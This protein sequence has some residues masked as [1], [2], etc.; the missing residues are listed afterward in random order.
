MKKFVTVALAYVLCTPLF[1]QTID[2]TAKLVLSGYV[3]AYYSYDFNQPL[4][5]DRPSFVYS[6]NRHN[7]FNLNLGF[8]KAAYV[9]ERIRGNIALMAGTYTNANLAAE[10]AT[11]RHIFEANAG[12]KLAKTKNL[13]LDAGV[14][15]SHIGFESAI[16]KDC[17]TLTRSLMADNTPY[18][19]TGAKIGYTTD[20]GKWFLSGLVLNGWQQIRRTDENTRLAVGTQITFKPNAKV[21]LNSSTFLGSRP[22]NTNRNRFFHNLYAIVQLNKKWELIADFDYGID[23][24]RPSAATY[25]AWTSWAAILKYQL[26]SK[27]GVAGRVENYSDPKGLVITTNSPNG[28]RVNGYSFNLDYTP[29][30]NALCRIEARSLGSKD[31]LFEKAGRKTAT[32]FIVTTSLAVSF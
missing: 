28:F 3:E 27:V 26:S 7:E 19:E 23:Q 6:H 25:D 10:P 32:D 5:N 4:N 11:L 13:W 17:R 15:S 14:F 20:D 9:D 30:S 2:S 29:I 16:S 24:Q 22:D 1:A 21:T 12:L 8:I 18:Y 31:D